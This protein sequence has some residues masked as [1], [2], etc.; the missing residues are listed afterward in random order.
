MVWTPEV[1]P[2]AGRRAGLDAHLSAALLVSP[3]LQHGGQ[4][5]RPDG[6][7]RPRAGCSTRRS[8]SS[9]PTAA[10]PGWLA[11]IRRNERHC[12]E[13]A[14]A[15]ALRSRRLRRVRRRCAAAEPSARRRWRARVRGTGA[16]RSPRRWRQLRRGDVIRVPPAAAPASPSSSTPACSRATTRAR[17]SSPRRRWGGRLSLVDFPAAVDVLGDGAGAR[18]TSTTARRRSAATSPSSIRALDMPPATGRARRREPAGADEDDEV[19]AAARRRCARTRVT[20]A[21]TASSTPAGPSGT[22]GSA[23]ENDGLRRPHRGPHRL[24]GPHLRPH[25]RAAGRRAATWPGTRRP[26]PGGGWPGSGRSPT[27]WSAECLRAGVWDGLDPAELAAVVSTLVYEPRRDEALVDAMP[28]AAVRDAL[29][30]TVRI[31]ADAGRRRGRRSAC[32]A[33]G[34]RETRVRLG[35]VPLGA[36][37]DRLDRVLAAA[38]ERGDELS[39]GD[40]IRWCKQVLDLLDQLAA[41]PTPARTGRAGGAGPRGR[42]PAS[43]AASW[44]RACR[45]E[46]ATRVRAWTVAAARQWVFRSSVSWASRAG[47]G[48]RPHRATP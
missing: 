23:R 44:R 46:V 6:P 29:A 8:R 34:S 12:A 36:R 38:A 18:S 17:W 3:V 22:A 32:R 2:A 27:W 5:G 14:A 48:D 19:V 37:Q 41:A 1:D 33:A 40:F 20:A 47:T 42:R 35:G 31:W 45:P 10:W 21:P 26:R 4:P 28:S 7:G 9:R 24:A 11:Q 43:A 13:Y 30:A 16:A 39:A 15:D 25:L